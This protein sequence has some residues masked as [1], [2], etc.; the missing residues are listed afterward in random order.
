ML[1]V[2]RTR[3]IA[4]I[5]LAAFAI[6]VLL[7]FLHS[8]GGES[9]LAR[10]K[11]ELRAKGDKLTFAEF[12]IPPST[13]LVHVACRDLFASNKFYFEGPTIEL[14]E[15][16]LP[17]RVK[18]A[19]RGKM[20]TSP[21][22]DQQD[23]TEEFDVGDWSE[24][25]G[26]IKRHSSKLEQF[27][28]ALINPAPDLGWTY[29]DTIQN[30]TNSFNVPRNS[31]TARA[32][33]FGFSD[34]AISKMRN[35]EREKAIDDLM[36]IIRLAQFD[37]NDPELLQAMIRCASVEYGTGLTWQALQMPGC[38]DGEL[39]AAQDGWQAVDILGPVERALMGERASI[40]I[41][42]E[43][44]RHTPNGKMGGLFGTST[45]LAGAKASLREY[46]EEHIVPMLYTITSINEDELLA[47]KEVTAEIDYIRMLEANRPW[48]EVGLTMS[49]QMKQF[50]K[51]VRA[52]KRLF[53]F[54]ISSI[55]VPSF[56]STSPRIGK[57]E[58]E[59]RLTIAA[60]AIKRYE[61]K[62]GKPPP[63]LQ[64]LAGIRVF[65][66]GADRFDERKAALLSVEERW[67]IPLVFR[68]TRR[69][70]RRRRPNS[71]D[72]QRQA[73]VMGRA[74]RGLA[75]GGVG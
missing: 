65:N 71:G 69:K 11:A 51:G 45:S 33:V 73:G 2:R 56:I 31:V 44:V 63:S 42:A 53:P 66:G 49:N 58:T 14:R 64:A 52:G 28:A 38:T 12:A 6:C 47:T 19:W 9:A 70:G 24:L 41:I 7:L 20:H 16:V 40:A 59:R 5:V 60:I 57:A 10:Y 72:N 54:Y 22:N 1:P 39:K 68:G 13:N 48:P 37:R 8:A 43:L 34:T 17:G 62:Y 25:D 32:V 61:L 21:T 74:G 35:G 50:E 15:Y 3:R 30:L 36:T 4:L 18:V 75:V 29:A 67:R 23:A 55:M 27:R 46:W 26:R